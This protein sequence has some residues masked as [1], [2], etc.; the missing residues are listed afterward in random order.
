MKPSKT[1]KRVAPKKAAPKKTV[2]KAI[3][4]A[5]TKKVAPKK[6]AP[7]KTAPK[8]A[9]K[10]VIKKTVIKKTTKK[11][12][13]KSAPK[14]GK[15]AVKK[16]AGRAKKSIKAKK[17]IVTTTTTVTTTT[18]TTKV[19]PKETH[20]LLILD[21][22]G[23]MGSVKKETLSGLN[24]QLKTIKNL[25]QKY[26]DQEYFVS[27][28]KFDDEIVPL[29][30]NIPAGK[31]NEL[32]E[33]D[34][35][36]DAMTALHD[37]IGISVEKLKARIESKLNTG[38]A[39]TLVVILT[40]GL[41]NASKEYDAARIKTLITDLEKTGMW[42]FTFIGANQDAI[43]TSRS[44]GINVNNTVNY[45]SS[46]KGTKLAFASVNSAMMKR[47][48]Y[49]DAG[50]YGATTCNFMSEVTRGGNSIGEDEKLLDLSGTVSAE[51]IQKAKD[52][53]NGTATTNASATAANGK[54]TPTSVDQNSGTQK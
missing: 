7:K 2:K 30:E 48:V 5:A 4:K 10:K 8:K 49:T 54:T 41:E 42:T 16:A 13:K 20:Y 51:D 28:I 47:A 27:I 23:S 35:R 15:K 3:K 19:N 50:A 1:K 43:L 24:E 36:P 38:E 18:V 11:A 39:S 6:N 21:E 46:G 26:P 40:D 45:S 14:K 37:A 9:V 25:E 29:F 31:V 33:N 22:S 52:S 53:L 34:Y 12:I 32:T 17:K 44:L